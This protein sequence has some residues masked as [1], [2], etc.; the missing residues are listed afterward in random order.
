MELTQKEIDAFNQVKSTVEALRAEYATVCAE[1]VA[2][3]KMLVELPVLPVPIEDFKAAILDFVDARGKDYL[4]EVVKK[5]VTDF[6][7]H[8]MSGIGVDNK[9]MGMPLGFNELERAIAGTAGSLSIARLVSK[10]H[11]GDLALYAFFGDLVKAGLAAAMDTM[12]D[13]DFGYD[14]LTSKDVGTDRATRRQ[15]IQD[16]QHQFSMLT[17]RKASLSSSLRQLGVVI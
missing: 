5:S 9:Y 15:A 6:S 1:I 13:A 10:E 8:M 7:T 12:S 11:T 3:E 17:A 2:T 14:G 16:A 4:N